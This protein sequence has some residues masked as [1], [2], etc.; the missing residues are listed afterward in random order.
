[1]HEETTN[2]IWQDDAT[3]AKL[4]VSQRFDDPYF[5]AVDGRAEAAYVFLSGNRLP[6]RW[7][8]RDSFVIGELGFGTGLNFLETWRQWRTARKPGQR[9]LFQSVEAYPLVAK[10]ALTALARWPDLE[11]DAKALWKHEFN[12]QVEIDQQTVLHVRHGF[13]D[14]LVRQYEPCDAWFLDGFSPAKNEAMW[15]AELMKA[16]FDRTL[17]DGTF[18]SYTAAGWVRRNLEAAGFSVERQPGF[19]RKR[20]MIVGT[21]P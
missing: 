14:H 18:A 16:V 3:G 20:H 4:P 1:M 10:D 2:L 5:S 8:D 11:A 21:R 13:A 19:G 9:L 15:S 6:E 12:G 7:R 17:T